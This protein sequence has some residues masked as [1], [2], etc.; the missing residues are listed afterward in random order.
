MPRILIVDD[1]LMYRKALRG[2]LE[3]HIAKAH[4]LEADSLESAC[5]RL[6][7]DGCIDLSLLD[8]STAGVSFE[9]LHGLH[10][11]Y[12]KTRLAAMMALATRADIMRSLDAGLY[13]F[14]S[15]SQSDSEILG[16]IKDM[17]SGRVY[18]PTLLTKVGEATNGSGGQIHHLSPRLNRIEALSDKLTPRQREVLAML[19]RGMSNK[20]IARAL[21]IAEGTTKIHASGVLRALGVRNRTEA[22]AVAKIHLATADSPSRRRS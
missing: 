13:G 10:E 5:K 3:S 20:E 17:L 2:A 15:K 18:V 16:A 11:C 7:P 1:H 19:A 9:A 8:L 4:V 22:A 14:V 12:P 21:R 6:D